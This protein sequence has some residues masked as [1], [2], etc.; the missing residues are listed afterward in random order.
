MTREE[1]AALL[2]WLRRPKAVWSTVTEQ[3]EECGSVQAAAVATLDA[4]GTLFDVTPTD[5]VEQAAADLE[6]WESTGIR[7]VS[8]L[9]REYPSNLRMIHQR[10][11]VLFLRGTADDR[12]IASVAVVGTR[13]ATP[14]GLNQAKDLAAGLAARGVP[15]ISGLAAGI[16]TAAHM[17][18]LA[19]G[20]RTVAVIGTGI[21]RAYPAQNVALQTEI[22]AKGLLISQ[23]LPGAPPTKTAFPM[24]NAVMSGY[25]LAT[26]VIEAAYQSGARMQARLALQHGR[27]VFLIRS[28]L[29]HDWARGYSERPAVTV[30]DNAEQV[31][32]GLQRLA[33]E[34][35]ESAELVWA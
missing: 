25:T 27:H 29:E 32:E 24:R 33:A 21:D 7:M 2:A 17:T 6:Q 3:L 9:D 1:Q 19:S 35:A 18:A 23:F 26:V 34:S 28:L 13:Q 15:V 22:A 20:G 30:V 5:D 10:P 14:Q 8:V 16:D 4:Q 11:P 12:D 31:F